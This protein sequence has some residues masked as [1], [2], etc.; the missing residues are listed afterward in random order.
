[1]NQFISEFYPTILSSYAS[2]RLIVLDDRNKIKNIYSNCA[3]H[4]LNEFINEN[5]INEHEEKNLRL[6]SEKYLL[7]SQ[8]HTKNKYKF[9]QFTTKIHKI[10]SKF[11]YKSQ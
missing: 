8:Q 9:H 4:P 2:N 7:I 3:M 1:M 10:K 11:K 5:D 6:K